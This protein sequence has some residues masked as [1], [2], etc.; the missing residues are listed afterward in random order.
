MDAQI[1]QTIPL[2]YVCVCVFER[3]DK[4][5]DNFCQYNQKSSDPVPLYPPLPPVR[6]FALSFILGAQIAQQQT[7][8]HLIQVNAATHFR[9]R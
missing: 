3:L 1:S 2:S 8:P 7:R 5:A 4:A 6:L 9:T